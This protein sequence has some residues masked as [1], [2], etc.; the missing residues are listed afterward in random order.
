MC[1]PTDINTITVPAPQTTTI[2]EE[3]QRWLEAE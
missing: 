3:F 1:K 2:T